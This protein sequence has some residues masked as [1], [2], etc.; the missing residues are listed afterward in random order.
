MDFDK[1]YILEVSADFRERQ[2]QELS[3]LPDEAFEKVIWLDSILEKPI[4]G[5]VIGNEVIDALPFKR[6]KVV[7]HKIQEIG[8]S[9]RNGQLIESTKDADKKLAEEV[10][11]I[12]K[13][14]N[15][16]FEQNYTSEIR[17]SIGQWLKGISSML[18]SGAILF[19]D[20]GYSRQ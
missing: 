20:Y 18:K 2:K 13:A 3:L 17:L 10:R 8:V 4:E 5:I 7:D 14:L 9:I 1:Y 15:R 12:E 11:L 19:I 16:D 6:F